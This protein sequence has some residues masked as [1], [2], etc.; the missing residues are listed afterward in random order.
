VTDLPPPLPPPPPPPGGF[1]QPAFLPPAGARVGLGQHAPGDP[2]AFALPAASWGQRAGALLLDLGVMALTVVAIGAVTYAI[3][4]DA[5]TIDR[6]I[7][8]DGTFV[9]EEYPHW[10]IA[11]IIGGFVVAFTYPWLVLG[12]WRGRTVGRRLVGIRVVRNDATPITVGHAF[13]REGVTKGLMGLFSM[14]LILSYLWPLWDRH[15]RAL[16]DLVCGTRVV[17]DST[18]TDAFGDDAY[19]RYAA[20]SAGPT[21]IPRRGQDDRDDLAGRIGLDG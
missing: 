5:S 4:G 6:S 2:P 1:P 9:V 11:A 8:D 3:A 19:A 14:P 13:L 20:P 15:Q 7:D 21:P 17:L 16:H 12:L 10:G 18:D